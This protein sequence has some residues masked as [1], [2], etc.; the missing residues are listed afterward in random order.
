MTSRVSIAVVD[1]H[2]VFR[3]G[4]IQLL[5]GEPEF[6]VVGEGES[7]SD[8]ICIVKSRQPN[9]I[10]LDVNMP[11]GGIEAARTISRIAPSTVVMMLTVVDDIVVAAEAEIAGAKGYILKGISGPNLTR[12]IRRIWGFANGG[13]IESH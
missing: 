6:D 12:E 8:A 11:G 9:V 1:D 13:A 4:V 5:T 2:A 3:G 10:I 7:A